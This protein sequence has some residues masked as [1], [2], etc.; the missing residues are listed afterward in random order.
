MGGVNYTPLLVLCQVWLKQF[1]PP[2]HNLQESDFSYD[3]KD[4]QG[5]KR[6]AVCAW[7][8]IRRIKDK[9]HYE[10]VTSGYEAW[11]ANRRKNIIDISREVVERGKETSFEQPNQWIEKSIEIEEKNRLL[12]QENE[13]LRKETS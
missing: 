8:S 13:K 11:Q 6:K 9:R 1:I 10:G 7:K 3:P 5:K 12:E 4:C 2:A